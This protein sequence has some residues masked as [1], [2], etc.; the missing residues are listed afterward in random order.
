MPPI[1]VVARQRQLGNV[2]KTTLFSYLSFLYVLVKAKSF[3]ETSVLKRNAALAV[4][5]VF[6]SR[7]LML[8]FCLYY[9]TT[10]V[11]SIPSHSP[12]PQASPFFENCMLPKCFLWV[13]LWHVPDL[14]ILTLEPRDPAFSMT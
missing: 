10:L 4:V 2:D 1:Y 6:A 12:I 9:D 5:T 14:F 8:P 3:Q 7:V 13:M 11:P